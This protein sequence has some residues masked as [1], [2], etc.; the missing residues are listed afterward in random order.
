MKNGVYAS[1][2]QKKNVNFTLNTFE[3]VG[4]FFNILKVFRYLYLVFLIKKKLS[5]NKAIV[6]PYFELHLQSHR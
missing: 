3:S 4:L 1:I 2:F 5:V 6:L